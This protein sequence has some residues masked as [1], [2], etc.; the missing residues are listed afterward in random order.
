[1]VRKN[2]LLAFAFLCSLSMAAQEDNQGNLLQRADSLLNARY[3]RIKYDTN[4]IS[5]PDRKWTLKLRPKLS[6]FDIRTETFESDGSMV[7]NLHSDPK[8]KLSLSA[9][10]S[11]VTLSFSLKPEKLRG[12]KELDYELRFDVYTRKFGFETELSQLKSLDGT[13]H[14]ESPL[15]VPELGDSVL[16]VD[17]PEGYVTQTNLFLS[18]Y[19]VFNHRRFSYPAAFTQ[20]YIQKRSAGS[21]IAGTYMGIS[22]LDA[23]DTTNY[24]AQLFSVK[25]GFISLGL[26]YGY[27]FVLP[28]NWLLHCSAIPYFVVFSHAKC[29]FVGKEEKW[30][31]KFP[32]CLIVARVAAIRSWERWF[33]GLTAHYMYT[34]L[35]STDLIAINNNRWHIMAIVGY[36]L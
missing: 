16:H 2:I 21:L 22:I 27:N 4:F 3:H 18:G 9:G 34:H 13:F 29:K 20:S 36:R 5:R 26:G 12:A 15:L 11:G 10:Y 30:E 25:N 7:L 31:A 32:Q 19:Y 6:Y 8:V 33:A 24:S 35:G 17:L 23:G 28:H 1:M 14:M